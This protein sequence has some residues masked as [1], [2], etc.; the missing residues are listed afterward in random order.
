MFATG[1]LRTLT[2]K[3]Y[4]VMMST[5]ELQNLAFFEDLSQEQL[6][7]LGPVFSAC[8]FYSGKTLF[9]QGEAT[10][11][12]YIVVH[13]EVVVKFKPDDGDIITVARVKPGGV[14]GWSAALNRKTYTSG[15][16]TVGLT[17]L[18]CVSGRDL[19]LVC[20]EHPGIGKIIQ[21]RLA[22]VIVERVS[23]THAHVKALLEMGLGTPNNA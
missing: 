19:R 23:K 10:N 15:A 14:V 17:R 11:L 5:D 20:R 6:A 7:I 2:L 21:D 4:Y 13:G 12:L 16:V 8:E 18:L 3:W 9:E 1:K 22:A